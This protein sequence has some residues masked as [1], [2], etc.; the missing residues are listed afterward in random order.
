MSLETARTLRKNLTDAERA[1]WRELRDKQIAGFR[2]R[3]QA[4]IGPY[5]VDFVCLSEK[6]VI[7]VDGGQ[8]AELAVED[9]RRTRW[10][11][12]RGYKVVRFW[13]NEVRQNIEGVV[14]VILRELGGGA[15]R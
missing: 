15:E 9:E 8:H 10:L 14:E 1:L 3:R 11:E 12:S 13:S 5:V 7:E 2:F 6:L 4:P